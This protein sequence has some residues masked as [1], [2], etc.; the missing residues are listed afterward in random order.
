[1]ARR[2]AFLKLVLP[3]YNEFQESWHQPVNENNETIDDWVSD[4]FESLIGESD[5]S[6]WSQLRGSM[7]S[8]ADRLDVAINPDGTIDVSGSSE[9]L[10]IATSASHG[11][12]SS[13]R[14]RLNEGDRQIYDARQPVAGDRFTAIAPAGP[15]AASPPEELDSGIALRAMDFGARTSQPISSPHTPWAPGLV[16]GGSDPFI[17]PFAT[18][19]VRL[20]AGNGAVFNIDGYAFRLREDVILDYNLIGGL[21]ANVYVWFYVARPTSDYNNI[22]YRYDGVGGTGVAVKDLRK[23]QSGTTGVTSTSIFTDTSARFNT[24]ALGKVKPGDVLVIE[25]G[26]AAGR[27]VIDAL[28]GTTP[29]IKLTIKGRFPANLSGL[30]WHVFDR[31][32]PNL[33]AVATDTASTSRPA[34]APGRVYIGRVRHQLAANPDQAVTLQRGGV[35]DSGWVSVDAATDFPFTRSHNLGTLPS[36]VQVWFRESETARSYQ[37]L[38]RRE[39]AG[40]D[41]LFPSVQHHCSEFEVTVLLLNTSTSPALGPS[42]F[43]DSAGAEKATGQIRVLAWS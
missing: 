19:Q 32:H 36:Q 24:A 7:P 34:F 33:G 30:T 17:T 21:G 1:M 18:G 20:N 14:E 4:L 3:E 25:S 10:D 2:T 9:I 26:V 43:T 38:V 42:L 41:L 35:Y 29:D 15:A 12:Y 31:F 28:D 16:V 11:Q 39:V 13:P 22:S 40:D 5:S 27:Y 6:T 37:P 8:L 23:L